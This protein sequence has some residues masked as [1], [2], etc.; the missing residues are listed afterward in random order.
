[1]KRVFIPILICG[2]NL[3]AYD[4]DYKYDFGG[5]LEYD[6]GQIETADEK[7]NEFALRRARISHKGSF[8][9][10]S[11]FYELEV[12]LA[13]FGDGNKE[14]DEAEYKDN[15]IGHK[16]KVDY[17]DLSYRI[18]VG[19][20]KVPFSFDSYAGSKNSTFME[21]PLTDTL[22][23]NRKIG[24]E[25]LFFKKDKNQRINLFLG[26]FINSIDETNDG[27][28]Q[29]TR[30]AIKTTYEYKFAKNHIF[31]FGAS[32]LYS[33][34]D[35]DNVK[36][37]QEAESNLIR[38]KYVSTKV[39]NV[40]ITKDS[41]LEALYINNSFHFQAEYIQ[42]EVDAQ[43]DDYTFNGY[44]AQVGYFLFGSSKTYKQSSAN[45]SAN[46]IID[47]EVEIAF[48]YSFVDLND[49]DEQGG[50]QKDY[51]FALNW[52]ISKNLKLMANY[53]QAYPLSD[54][55]NGDFNLFQA[56]TV[57]SF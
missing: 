7:Y 13:N 14:N 29:K 54:T 30:Y 49:K 3:F 11:L 41:A 17:L 40:I 24:I 50:T 33:D 32:Y 38:D 37:S 12:D 36:Y 5:R 46:K 2:I 27:E 22:T 16:N 52:Y 4:M 42:S 48:R 9:G 44:Y 45:F 51:N 15:Y 53:I 18:K 39:K 57:I 8:Y 28:E 43:S 31:H 34:I 1:M 55:Y 6:I 19:N 35:G 56:R 23:Q 25:T 47:N 21:S 20:I 26:T 10:K